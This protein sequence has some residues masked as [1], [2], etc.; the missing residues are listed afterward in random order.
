[1]SSV[2][3]IV[4]PSLNV[5]FHIDPFLGAAGSDADDGMAPGLS[6]VRI[7]G[8]CFMAGVRVHVRGLSR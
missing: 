4:P 7:T 6:R 2:A 3:I 5:A 1:M 8:S